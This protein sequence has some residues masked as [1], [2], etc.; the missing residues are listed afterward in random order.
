MPQRDD[1]HGVTSL[2]QQQP[3]YGSRLAIAIFL[4]LFLSLSEHEMTSLSI[5]FMIFCI[6]KPIKMDYR[7][8]S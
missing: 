8:I 2:M 1:C 7:F 6:V 5:I 3:P 4:P